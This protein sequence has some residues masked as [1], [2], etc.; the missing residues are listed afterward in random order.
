MRNGG[1]VIA[2]AAIERAGGVKSVRLSPTAIDLFGDKFSKV[3]AFGD[4]PHKLAPLLDWS[5]Q[6]KSRRNPS[7]H[8]IPLAVIPAVLDQDQAETFKRL[9]AE[10][11][12]P[13]QGLPDHVEI[14]HMAEQQVAV[15]RKIEALGVYWPMFAHMPSEG[16]IPIYPTVAEDVGQMVRAGRIVLGHLEV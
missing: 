4:L 5:N 15:R 14:T 8:R 6:L 13:P 1:H 2:C 7:A 16:A 3:E 12:A 9:T 11:T 10:M